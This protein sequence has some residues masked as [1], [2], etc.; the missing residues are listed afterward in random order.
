MSQEGERESNLPPPLPNEMD[1]NKQ[2][3]DE[4]NDDMSYAVMRAEDEKAVPEKK[5]NNQEKNKE[6][7]EKE[8]KENIKDKIPNLKEIEEAIS[9][10]ESTSKNSCDYLNSFLKDFT[11][12]NNDLLKEI[13]L[14][15]DSMISKYS[16]LFNLYEKPSHK[17]EG[18]SNN[19]GFKMATEKHIQLMRKISDT[20]N[21]IFS[22]LKQN[23]QILSKFIDKF[24]NISQNYDKGRPIQDFLLDEFNNIVDCW[25]FMKIDF[26]KFDFNEA[27]NKCNLEQNFKSFVIKVSKNKNFI[28]KIICP[29]GEN[30][31]SPIEQ[32][33]LKEKKD[34]EIKLLTE[35]K[36]NLTKLHMENVGNVTSY[37]GDKLEFVK[38]KKFHVE[39]STIQTGSLFKMM[40][41][42]EKLTIKSCPSIQIDLLEFLPPKIKKLILEKNNFVN[43]E[44]EN[45]LKGILANNKN[46]LQNLEYLSFAGNNLTRV[47]LSI[48]PPKIQFITLSKMNFQKNKIYKFIYNPENFPNL[49]FINCC[50]NNLNKS[51]LSDMKNLGSLES[52]NGFLFEPELCVKYFNKLKERLAEKEN[53]IFLSKYL[54]ISF[55]PKVHTLKYFDNFII[56]EKVIINL[57][58]LDLSFNGL[59]CNTFFGFVNQ[60]KGF[61]NLRSLNLTGNELD[62]TFFERFLEKNVFTKLQHLYLNSNKIGLSL[63]KINYKD[64]IPIDPKYTSHQ[65][66]Q[67]VKL[68]RLIYD[69]IEKNTF[70]NKLTITK[71][72]IGE[73]YSIVP[74]AKN[75]ADKSDK[76]ILRDENNKIII[77]C[78]FSLLVKIRDELLQNEEDKIERS[79]FNLRFDCR[80]NVNRNSENYPYIDKPIVFKK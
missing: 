8:N 56:N 77:N 66:K 27:L 53:N 39:N 29:K 74:E 24:L 5:E 62:D 26:E 33:K 34:K 43:F 52:G 59:D 20:Y 44:L 10:I 2:E 42:L 35:N 69:F 76:Y 57:T 75:N 14:Y 60:N 16:Q 58:K 22:S 54:N 71:N 21:Q 40:K 70:L 47:D 25:L 38:L 13:N 63:D 15:K 64:N 48:L 61:I 73:F 30:L 11:V 3:N 12:Q 9:Q 72:P 7:K 19:T 67:L 6:K 55:M 28:L 68:L 17:E 80:S 79:N 51:Y 49:K 32:K 46:I 78:L 65:E 23:L 45:I 1:I 50:K 4:N 41:N 31:N 36:G 18:V 37:T